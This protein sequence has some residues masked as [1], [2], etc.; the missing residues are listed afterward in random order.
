MTPEKE[1][2]KLEP[3]EKIAP[4]LRELDEFYGRK[5]REDDPAPLD[6]LVR[7]VL[8]Q[9]TSDV[10]SGRAWE[11]L[12]E[13]FDDWESMADASHGQIA[14]AIRSGGLADQKTDTIQSILQWLGERGHYSLDFLE[15][16]DSAEAEKLL[17]SIKG[18]GVKT[19]RLVLLFGLDRPVFVVDTHVHRVSRRLGLIPPKAGRRKAHLILD[20][21]VPDE[22]KYSGHLNM[23][24][25]GRR[26]CRSQSPL[27]DECPVRRWCLY[28]RGGVA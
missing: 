22:D 13:A 7:G 8:S 2:H 5:T 1:P 20:E 9:N 25:H 19:A 24:Q 11:S 4:V 23:I 18:V 6:V 14:D 16:M 12:M 21:L 10:N 28:V 15:D 17:K 3:S 26:T 27:C